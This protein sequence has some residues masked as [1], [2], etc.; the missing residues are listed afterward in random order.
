MFEI[1]PIINSIKDGI[2]SVNAIS[3]KTLLL[4]KD[5]FA[6]F[7][8]NIFGLSNI[9]NNNNEVL[10]PVMELLLDLRKDAKSKKDFTT[11]DRIRN[12]LTDMGIVIKDDK[13]GNSSWGMA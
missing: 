2:I 1:A 10:I 6:V 7:L 5:R 9:D 8:E 11:S 3:G 12:Q 4:M 13:E